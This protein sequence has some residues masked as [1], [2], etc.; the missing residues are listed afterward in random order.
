MDEPFGFDFRDGLQPDLFF[1][2]PPWMSIDSTD[3]SFV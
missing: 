2:L 1:F 3:L